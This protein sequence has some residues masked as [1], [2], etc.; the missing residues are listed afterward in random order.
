[1]GEQKT[2]LSGEQRCFLK[3]LQSV[4]EKQNL[5]PELSMDE[6]TMGRLY[7]LACSQSLVSVVYEYF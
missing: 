4:L 6:K 7:W 1:M 2:Q 3:I 5:C